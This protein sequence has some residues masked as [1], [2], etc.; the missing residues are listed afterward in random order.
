MTAASSWQRELEVPT[1]AFFTAFAAR[2][3]EPDGV[4]DAVRE[5]VKTLIPSIDW[6]AYQPHVPHGILGLRA[7]LRLQPCLEEPSFLRALAIQLHMAATEG[8]RS[9]QAMSQVLGAKGSGFSSSSIPF[10]VAKARVWY[11]SAFPSR[12]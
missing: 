5:A 3:I 4:R 6:E 2:V 8:R 10:G 11:S 12:M 9:A 1:E 7:V